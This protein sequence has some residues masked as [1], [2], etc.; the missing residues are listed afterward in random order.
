MTY[1]ELQLKHQDELKRSREA[2]NNRKARTRRL[3][4]YGAIAESMLPE[5][6]GRAL[7]PEEFQQL[8]YSYLHSPTGRRN[9][10]VSGEDVSQ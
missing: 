8:L 1:T 10:D 7:S 6:K 2:I 5:A 9:Q 3:I 4:Q